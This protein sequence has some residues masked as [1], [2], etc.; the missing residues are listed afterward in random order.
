MFSFQDVTVLE[1]KEFA[2]PHEAQFVEETAEDEED[3]PDYKTRAVDYWKSGK[4]KPRTL[5]GVIQKFKKVK[6]LRQLRRWKESVN[7]GGTHTNKLRFITEYVLTNFENSILDG[8][9]IHD[10]DL[11]RWALEA[12]EEIGHES[13]KAGH[14]WI[15]H[16]KKVLKIVS[17]KIT[18][19]ITRPTR[20][21]MGNLRLVS[22]TFI[23]EDNLISL[24][25]AEATYTTLM[26][27]DLI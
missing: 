14:W 11:R 17:R 1:F 18:K 4:S 25:S 23:N 5:A 8:K 15:W 6:S 9:V 10:M 20:T 27:A 13:F 24:T 2:E 22:D 3:N 21:D 19:F 7:R 12:K 16:F 26:R